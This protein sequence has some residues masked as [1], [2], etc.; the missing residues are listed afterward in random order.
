MSIYENENTGL[1]NQ[2][3]TSKNPAAS[4]LEQHLIFQSEDYTQRTV[5][6]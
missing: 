1:N 6:Q 4:S 5:Q 3:F 2:P